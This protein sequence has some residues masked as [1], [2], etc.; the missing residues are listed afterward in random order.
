M[1]ER[2]PE[3]LADTVPQA[4]W[5]LNMGRTMFY[6]LVKAGEIKIIKVGKK[7]LVPRSEQRRYIEKRMQAAA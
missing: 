7:T 6:G 5:N 4:C 3:R 1:L 2:E